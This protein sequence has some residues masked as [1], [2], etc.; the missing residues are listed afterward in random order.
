MPATIE[1]RGFNR[2]AALF[3]ERQWPFPLQLPLSQ[4]ITGHDLLAMLDIPTDQVEILFINGKVQFLNATVNPGDRVALVSPGTPGP[5]RVL[6]GFV[7][8]SKI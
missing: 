8:K 7:D 1:I 5:Y 6:L 4:A 2:L 3:R